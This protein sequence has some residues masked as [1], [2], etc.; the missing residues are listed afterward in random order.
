MR[1]DIKSGFL[2]PSKKVD[3]IKPDFMS[4]RIERERVCS[5]RGVA[6]VFV[7]RICPLP[8]AYNKGLTTRIELL[9]ETYLVRVEERSETRKVG[10][11]ERSETCKVKIEG[12]S[13]TCKD[14]KISKLFEEFPDKHLK[15]HSR[16]L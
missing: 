10:V 2:S 7:M 8:E 9:E 12:E 1:D 5:F 14:D 3:D 15:T 16:C 4:S 6:N 11:E 13:K